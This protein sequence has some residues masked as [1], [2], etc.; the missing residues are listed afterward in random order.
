MKQRT[1]YRP[2][3]VVPDK[4]HAVIGPSEAKAASNMRLGNY[5]PVGVAVQPYDSNSG[6]YKALGNTLI[7]NELLPDSGLNVCVG[8]CKDESRNRVVFANWNAEGN[9]ALYQ[10]KDDVFSVIIELPDLPNQEIDMDLRGDILIWTDNTNDPRTVNIEKAIAGDYG[11]IENWKIAQLHRRPAEPLVLI[12]DDYLGVG[13][14]IPKPDDTYPEKAYQFAYNY[15]YFDFIESRISDPTQM[16]WNPSPSFNIPEGELL[17]LEEGGAPNPYITA[18]KFYFRIG[19]DGAWNI[20]KKVLPADI[21]PDWQ[22]SISEISELASIGGVT[23]SALLDIDGIGRTVKNNYFADNRII[24]AGIKQGYTVDLPTASVSVET[25]GVPISYGQKFLPINN[26][27]PLAMV[28]YDE[29]DRIIGGRVL[30]TASITRP[31]PYTVSVTAVQGAAG[32]EFMFTAKWEDVVDYFTGGSSKNS[33]IDIRDAQYIRITPSGTIAPEIKKAVLA[34]N[35]KNHALSFIRTVCRPYYMYKAE[36]GTLVSALNYAETFSIDNVLYSFYGIGFAFES[37]E[38]INFS[39]QQNYNI[40]ILGYT[41]SDQW[42]ISWQSL[43]FKVTD[44]AGN[45]LVC[46][47]AYDGNF[48]NSRVEVAG[49]P[50][51]IYYGFKHYLVDLCL[52]SKPESNASSLWQIVPDV[53][54]DRSELENGTVK[55]YLGNCYSTK[56]FTTIG[57]SNRT[58]YDSLGGERRIANYADY[59]TSIKRTGVFCSMNMNGT[60]LESWDNNIGNTVTIEEDPIEVNL[61][62][63]LR[64]G[65]QALSNTKINNLFAFN[66]QDEETVSSQLGT[67]TRVTSA[68]LDSTSGENLIVVCS[69]G[70][71]GVFLSRVLIQDNSGSPTLATSTRVFGSKNTYQQNFGAQKMYDVVKSDKSLI[72]FYDANKK[73]LGQISNN[74]VD[75][76]SEQKL[77]KTDCMRFADQS[78]SFIG[79]DPFYME[80]LVH[81]K[82][83]EGLA[84]NF[85]IDAYQGKRFFGGASPSEMFAY[86]GTK[87][88]SFFNGQLYL[89]NSNTEGIFNGEA[90]LSDVAL[91]CNESLPNNKEIQSV[92]YKCKQGRKWEV[93][94]YSDN[95]MQTEMTFEEFLDRK[96]FFE[97]GA[98]RDINSTGGKYNGDMVDGSFFTIIVKDFDSSPKDLNFV[99]IQTSNALT[100]G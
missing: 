85:I 96:D 26:R 70:S 32:S 78:G 58:T 2:T 21:F 52:Y 14:A 83:G 73:A 55:D 37:E 53:M 31:G 29:Y 23:A 71:T 13:S 57:Q 66:P 64:H 99:E 34:T 40:R 10:Y 50:N 100:N 48:F 91:V 4:D 45:I 76:L 16:I 51:D 3:K 43:D 33:E 42:P 80:I 5:R 95:G 86:I 1:I 28:F 63:S 15:V 8:W 67:I 69:L 12:G 41:T 65:G 47:T 19:N 9:S 81:Q 35:P 92:I 82:D 98:N 6:I 17:Y 46:K 60:L 18:I 7:P 74:G 75:I 68:A 39:D 36:D 87:A 27:V 56:D 25:Y 54:W 79:Y 72:F 11:T 93:D 88:Y 61:T 89:L 77:F 24:H 59:L 44:Q 94:V 90:Y 30:D 49:V 22:I 62:N 84:H 38:P 20:F 97:S